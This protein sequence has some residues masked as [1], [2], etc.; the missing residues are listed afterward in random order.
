MGVNYREG[1]HCWTLQISNL[2][3]K[4]KALVGIAFGAPKDF[5]T[6]KLLDKNSYLYQ[7]DGKTQRGLKE[8]RKN[9]PKLPKNCRVTLTLNLQG[10]GKENGYLSVSV[11]SQPPV[12]LFTGLLDVLTGDGSQGKGFGPLI[13]LNEEYEA[14]IQLVDIWRIA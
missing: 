5:Q 2:Q 1:I 3:K 7:A 12:T 6:T 4:S 14:T 11:D 10:G 13:C 9:L 8:E